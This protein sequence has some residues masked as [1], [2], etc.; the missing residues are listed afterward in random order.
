MMK[1]S[2]RMKNINKDLDKNKSYHI[3]E[4][5]DNLKKSSTVKFKES[6]DVA[7]SLGIDTTKSDQAVRGIVILPEITGKIVRVA[8]FT[9][10]ADDIK[11]AKASSA[12]VIGFDDLIKDI[13]D[14]NINFDKLITTPNNMPKLARLAKILGPKGMMPNPKL[15]TVVENVGTAIKNIKKG[16][17]E[18][19]ADS[20]GVIHM[21]VA[22]I[23]MD[24]SAVINNIK[25]LIKTLKE[26]KPENSKGLYLKTV[27]LSSSMGPGFKIDLTSLI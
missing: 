13:T 3:N 6:I 22:K 16:Q 20:S 4:A 26:A 11:Q 8:V 25:E 5:I 21:S 23:D 15:G 14:G 1:I 24:N 19:R 9:D 7:V 12:D 18:F 10:D 27:S 2:K 17:V